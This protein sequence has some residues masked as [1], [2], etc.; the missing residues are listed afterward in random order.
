MGNSKDT[1]H[2]P[3]FIFLLCLPVSL[4]GQETEVNPGKAV[5]AKG[6]YVLTVDDNWI[7]LQAQEASLKA[8]LGEIGQ[9]MGVEVVE[10]VSPQENITAEFHNL[11]LE[12]ALHRLSPN[13]GYQVGSMKGNSRIT[14]IFALPTGSMKSVSQATSQ[15]IEN[16][17]R[18]GIPNDEQDIVGASFFDK[19]KEEGNP[20]PPAPFQFEF[21]PSSFSKN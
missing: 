13:Y 1:R 2:I 12:Q 15:G 17:D 16:A 20:S 10:E 4:F 11:P 19:A 21:D 3:I 18:T 7:S 8:I 14:K 6:S 5:S 9:K